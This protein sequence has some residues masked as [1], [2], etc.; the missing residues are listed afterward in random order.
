MNT[1]DCRPSSYAEGQKRWLRI[2]RSYIAAIFA[3]Y[4]AA[5]APLLW[6]QSVP[7]DQ[8]G[9]GD[10]KE[11]SLEQLGNVQ[12]TTVS[13]EPEKLLQTPAAIYV[14]TQDDIRRAGVTSIPEALRLVPGVEVAR[15]DSDS[16]AVGIRGFGGAFSRSVL[17]L[18][19]GRSVYTPLFEGVYWDVQNVMLEDVDRIEVIRGPGG[20]IWGSNAVN[21]VINII[22]K[23]AND[24]QGTLAAVGGGNV[25]QATGAV[26]YGGSYGKDFDYRVYGMGFIRGAEYHV[27]DDPFDEWR[28]GQMGF[29]TDWRESERDTITFQ[30]DTYSGENGSETNIAFFSPPSQAN[31]DATT[32]VSG[33]NLLTRWKHQ[34]KNG[35]DFQLEAYFDRTNRQGVQ[36]GE[37]RDT[38][39]LDFIYHMKLLKD[40]DFI[41]GMGARLSPSDFIQTQA[42]VNFLPNRQTDSIYSGF[43]Q[44]QIPIVEDKLS[45]TVGTKLEHNNFSGFDA[46]PSARLLWSPSDKQSFWAA[47]TRALRTPSRLDQ[48]LALTGLVSAAPPFPIFLEITGD[49]TYKPEQLIGYEGGYRSAVNPKFYLDIATFFNN[50]SG[51]S[52]LGTISES[53]AQSPGPSS[54]PYLLISVPWANGIEGNTDG[55]EISPDWKVTG[56][57]QLRG[58]YSYL[59]MHLKDMPGITDTSTVPSDE[60]SSPHHEVVIQSLLDLPKQFEFDPTYRYVSALPAQGVQQYSTMDLHLGWHLGQQLEVSVTG[61][62]LFRP[63][64]VEYGVGVNGAPNV[65]VKRGSY[66]QITWRRQ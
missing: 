18:I 61:E 42:T 58:S 4:T 5:A 17:V 2:T 63:Y 36:F 51:L 38:F 28:M 30:G 65:G 66:A 47:V 46:Q 33:G 24:T 57:W 15:I 14:L 3:M 7:D 12:V 60:G 16:W 32:F 64:Q 26:R 20:T 11:L 41:W 53:F 21:G 45:V 56:W 8:N 35:S 9:T 39:D 31:V 49:P 13:K 23:T 10:L 19:D 6:A 59:Q 50:Y 43:L 54:Y 29:R 40:Q 25:D 55:A 1:K 48:D 34:L 52:S 44:D 22:T 27:N 62:N 37:T